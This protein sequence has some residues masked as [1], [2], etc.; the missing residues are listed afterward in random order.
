M[1]S[2]EDFKRLMEPTLTEPEQQDSL[3][4]LRCEKVV[5]SFRI[6]RHHA[7]RLKRLAQTG[8]ISQA[9]LLTMMINKADI[10]PA[11]LRWK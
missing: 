6:E 9:K 2:D 4:A 3:Q 10:T 7:E 11:V 8:G 1:M 5:V